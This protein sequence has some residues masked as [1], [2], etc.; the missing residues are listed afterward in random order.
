MLPLIY[1]FVFDSPTGRLLA[2]ALALGLAL[3]VGWSAWKNTPGTKDKPASPKEKQSRG[4]Q[5]LAFGF[6]LADLGLWYATKDQ[7][8]LV[9]RFM[10]PGKGEGIPLHTYGI[11]IGTGFMLAVTASA[12]MAQREWPG[13]LGKE[14]RDQVF[15]MA[16]YLFLGGIIGSRVLFIIVNFKQYAARPSEMLS[17]GGGLVFQGGLVGAAG[18]GYWYCKK[19]GME[20]LRLLDF[21]LPTVSLG[22]A[23]GRLGC[24]SAGCCWGRVR[25]ADASLAVHFPG[26]GEVKNLFGGAGDTASLAYQSMSDGAS[27]TRWVLEATGEVFQQAVPGAVRISEW[28]QQHQHTLPVHPVQLYESVVQIVLFLLFV[29]LRRFRRFHGQIAGMWL[30][31][32]AIERGTVETFRGDSER[33]TLAGALK[34]YVS[35]DPNAWFNISTSQLGSMAIFVAGTVLLARQYREWRAANPSLAAAS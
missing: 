4:L 27:E 16:F 23:F 20:F 34:S 12:W 5:Y 33:G 10:G 32:Y 15:D 3:Y 31:A 24:F 1:R 35:I 29:S 2:Y 7:S 13:A 11:L 19:T 22:A 26:T 17:L 6:L 30:M 25:P 14:R 21:G 9:G 28:A 8:L 18:V